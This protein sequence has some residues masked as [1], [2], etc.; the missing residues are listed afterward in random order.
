MLAYV[1]ALVLMAASLSVCV[2]IPFDCTLL[3]YDLLDPT[4]EKLNIRQAPHGVYVEN[5]ASR[6]VETEA[7]LHHIIEEGDKNR[8]TASTKMNTTSSRSHLILQL[9]IEAY[10]KISRVTNKGRLTLVD[11]AGSERVG[12]TGV[13]G[14]Q[15][16]EAAAINKSLSTLGNVRNKIIPPVF[17]T[18][19]TREDPLI[20]GGLGAHWGL[21]SLSGS[22][23][24]Y[25]SCM[26]TCAIPT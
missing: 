1:R 6:L 26:L 16:V 12:K 7:D 11:L 13:G 19:Y 9:D 23:A 5:L 3:R 2:T 10:N 20:G 17:V 24:S 25:T 14:L 4:R 22:V 18:F 15:L 21:L 8:T